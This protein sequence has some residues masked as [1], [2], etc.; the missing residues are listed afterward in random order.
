[1]GGAGTPS[2]TARRRRE[3]TR[4]TSSSSELV[5][6]V[7]QLEDVL[8]APR[9]SSGARPILGATHRRRRS[10]SWIWPIVGVLVVILWTVALIDIVRRRRTMSGTRIVVWVLVLFLL[11]VL[12]AI[13][14]FVVHSGGGG[15]S[16][17][18]RD[19]ALKDA[20]GHF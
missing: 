12:G 15:D 17:A 16:T 10:M 6:V 4:N 18:P 1:V 8:A 9:L 3:L 13:V 11:P 2:P 14:Y 7:G 20:G 5:M 19:E